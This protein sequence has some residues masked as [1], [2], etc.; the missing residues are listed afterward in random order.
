MSVIDD[1]TKLTT[2]R[3]PDDWTEVD[4][5]AVNT[6]RVLAADAVQRNALSGKQSGSGSRNFQAGRRIVYRDIDI[7]RFGDS[8][9]RQI[10]TYR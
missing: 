2:P 8:R 9:Q 5:R 6:I 4:T 7:G 1:L 10:N 3:V